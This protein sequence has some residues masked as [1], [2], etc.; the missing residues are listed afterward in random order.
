MKTSKVIKLSEKSLCLIV[1]YLSL[2]TFFVYLIVGNTFIDK[3]EQLSN[4]EVFLNKLPN[5]HFPFN[6]LQVK[7]SFEKIDWHDWKF[8]EY[9][10]TRHGPGEQGEGVRLRTAKEIMQNRRIAN[11]QGLSAIISDKISVNRSVP[12]TRHEK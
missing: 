6:F 4:D 11:F 10:I 2:F 7:R 1:F 5:D 12:D 9:E 8:V 3:M